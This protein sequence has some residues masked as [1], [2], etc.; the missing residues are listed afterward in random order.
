M[1]ASA[2]KSTICTFLPLRVQIVHAFR[3]M[4]GTANAEIPTRSA[5]W[6]EL[7]EIFPFVSDDGDVG[8]V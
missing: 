8:L 4:V 7:S 3:H 6:L 2:L 5:L 1:Y